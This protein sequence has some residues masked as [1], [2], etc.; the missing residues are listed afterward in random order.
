MAAASFTKDRSL[1][2]AQRE[3]PKRR[4][5][6]TGGSGASYRLLRDVSSRITWHISR[7]EAGKKRRRSS[8]CKRLG[9]NQC[10]LQTAKDGL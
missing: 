1:G 2:E 3:L 8:I 5:I 10:R 4:V 6:V 7:R 9:G